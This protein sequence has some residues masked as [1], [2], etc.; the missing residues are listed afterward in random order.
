M[1]QDKI[2]P[3]KYWM[4]IINIHIDTCFDFTQLSFNLGVGQNRMA[5]EKTRL[6][7]KTRC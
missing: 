5:Q 3:L 6:M 7:K 1:A 4:Q 2:R